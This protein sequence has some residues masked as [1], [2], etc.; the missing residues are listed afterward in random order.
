LP[1]GVHASAGCRITPFSLHAAL[2]LL[3]HLMVHE[4]V[5]AGAEGEL[6]QV[7]VVA[8]AAAEGGEG[9]GRGVSC[10]RRPALRPPGLARPRP[11]ADALQG[12]IL[13]HRPL[14][15]LVV[16]KVGLGVARAGR[17]RHVGRQPSSD[18]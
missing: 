6:A 2:T 10:R 14:H 11:G 3:R 4:V 1:T 18:K 8:A 12:Q 17:G 9:V 13:L 5:D 15:A 16:C 7:Q